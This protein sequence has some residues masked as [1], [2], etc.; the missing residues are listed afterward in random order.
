MSRKKIRIVI[1]AVAFFYL[2][3]TGLAVIMLKDNESVLAKQTLSEI[4]R[5]SDRNGG[6]DGGN[7]PE[8]IIEDRTEEYEGRKTEEEGPYIPPITE[9]QTEDAT[10]SFWENL[11]EEASGNTVQV[12]TEEPTEIRTEEP[13]DKKTEEPTEI[14]TEEPT[15]KKTEEPT[16]TKTEETTEEGAEQREIL[17][18]QEDGKYY[19]Y[20][21]TNQSKLLLMRESPTQRSKAIAELK[22]HTRGGVIE[23]GDQW[24]KVSANGKIGYCFTEY[25]KITEAAKEEYEELLKKSGVLQ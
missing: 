2:T 6:S 4:L 16:E 8:L 10:E 17:L 3:V 22:P 7:D 18:P 11:T 23:L 9:R 13:T 5:G 25:I 21:S 1:L 24:T 14:R 12:V 20:E 15:D 19:V